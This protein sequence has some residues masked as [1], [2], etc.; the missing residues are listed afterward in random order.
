MVS[1]SFMIDMIYMCSYV[2]ILYIS[3]IITIFLLQF[4]IALCDQ[5]L[6]WWCILVIEVIFVFDRTFFS[7]KIYT[8]FVPKRIINVFDI[9][10]SIM[11]YLNCNV[12]TCI[13][14]KLVLN[15]VYFL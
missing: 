12:N 6:M 1:F 4:I 14:D 13:L 8:N 15:F 9:F 2:T 5:I 10:Y 3:M 7:S 11:D